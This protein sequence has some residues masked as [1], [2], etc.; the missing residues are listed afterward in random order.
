[1]KEL[2]KENK[3]MIAYAIKHWLY[4]IDNAESFEDRPKGIIIFRQPNLPSGEEVWKASRIIS[5][6]G[7]DEDI[8]IAESQNDPRWCIVKENQNGNMILPEILPSCD[9]S[10][11]GQDNET[12]MAIVEQFLSDII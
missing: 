8:W 1:M 6:D 12:I 9:D 10:L 2:S 3:L 7:V 11:I 4:A 5:I